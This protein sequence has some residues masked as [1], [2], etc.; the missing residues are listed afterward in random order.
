MSVEARKNFS[1]VGRELENQ[2][3]KLLVLLEQPFQEAVDPTMK[4]VHLKQ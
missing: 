1:D 2:T 3:Q 4:N